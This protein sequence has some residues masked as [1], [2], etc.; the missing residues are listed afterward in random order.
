MHTCQEAL[1]YC[2]AARENA[3]LLGEPGTAKTSIVTQ[4]AK[5]IARHIETI[6]ASIREPSDFGGLPIL[7]GD[8]YKLAPPAWAKR[9]CE[10]EDP[11]LFIDEL[12]TAPP[13]VQAALLRVVLDRVVGELALPEKTSV[14]AAGN[15][16]DHSAGGW[17][18]AAPLANRFVHIPWTLP[19][20]DWSEGLSA[21]AWPVPEVP[22]LIDGW[23]DKFGPTERASVAAFVDR[24]PHLMCVVPSDEMSQGG[25]WPSP[26]TWTMAANLLAACKAGG[27]SDEAEVMLVAGCV[28]E[29]HAI[30]FLTWRRN[31]DLP[32]PEDLLADPL[33]A[34]LPLDRGDKAYV[35]LSGVAAAAIRDK[36]EK[37]WKAGWQIL[38]RAADQGAKDVAASAARTLARNLPKTVTSAPPEA[39]AFASVLR[40]AGLM[41][42]RK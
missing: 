36:D 32:D 26:R 8:G 17:A 24:K 9:L 39:A 18:L 37:R 25:A 28:G 2:I 23:R 4:I 35:V 19:S 21:G 30:E 1:I 16:V 15:P 27:A 42:K 20:R 10:H 13:A 14:I 41:R 40:A 31:L 29:E 33:K 5:A 12:P 11:I 3:N 22:K 6:I 38:A 34:H 7:D